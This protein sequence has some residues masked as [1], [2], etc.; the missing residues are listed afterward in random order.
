M[1]VY[2]HQAYY[3]AILDFKLKNVSL[4]QKTEKDVLKEWVHKKYELSLKK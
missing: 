1:K 3:V 2:G 4:N